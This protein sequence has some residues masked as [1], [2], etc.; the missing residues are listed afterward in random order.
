MKRSAVSHD[1]VKKQL[2]INPEK[3]NMFHKKKEF[4]M[5]NKIQKTVEE[6]LAIILEGL[7]GE[8]PVSEICSKHGISQAWY[9]S[10]RDKFLEGGKKALMQGPGHNS[11]LAEKAR[12]EE[13]EKVIGRQTVEIQILKKNLNLI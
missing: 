7:K 5:Q 13:L 11:S 10:L 1:L 8:I 2:P 6:K 12:I 3:L 4:D 9:Y